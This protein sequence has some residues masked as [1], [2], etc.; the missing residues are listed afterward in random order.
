MVNI[1]PFPKLRVFGLTTESQIRTLTQTIKIFKQ[2][3]GRIGNAHQRAGKIAQFVRE[4]DILRAS[5]GLPP[6]VFTEPFVAPIQ[7]FQKE[8]IDKVDFVGGPP[9]IDDP[10]QTSDPAIRAQ[11]LINPFTNNPKIKLKESLNIKVVRIDG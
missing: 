6:S 7:Q 8:D 2:G 9:V 10:R 1:A 3:G 5:I 4:L 11:F